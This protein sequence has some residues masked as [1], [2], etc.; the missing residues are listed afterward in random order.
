M[1]LCRMSDSDF[2]GQECACADCRHEEGV[3][4]SIDSGS[5]CGCCDGPVTNCELGSYMY[6]FE[7]DFAS[8]IK[9]VPNQDGDE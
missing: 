8:K 1:A 9:C 5:G 3:C 2:K 7:D 4:I 6:D